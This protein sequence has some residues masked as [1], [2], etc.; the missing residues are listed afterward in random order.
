MSDLNVPEN[1]RTLIHDLAFV[2]KR[3]VRQTLMDQAATGMT[4]QEVGEA[5]IHLLELAEQVTGN[6]EEHAIGLLIAEGGMH[7]YQAERINFPSLKGAALGLKAA[8]RVPEY[9]CERLCEGCAYRQGSV[10]NQCLPT[11]T[12]V[13][14]ALDTEQGFN[15]HING[16]DEATDM[17]TQLC[18]GY[19]HAKRGAL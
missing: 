11:Q 7:P 10:A 6:A 19:V 4:K 2:E 3:E 16:Y 5:M 15:C 8:S 14:W 9:G 13:E 1:V 17:P 18:V 12:D